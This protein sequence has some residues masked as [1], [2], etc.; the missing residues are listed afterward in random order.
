MNMCYRIANVGGRSEEWP[1]TDNI[2]L[3][4]FEIF[5][6]KQITQWTKKTYTLSPLPALL[7]EE[8]DFQL[9]NIFCRDISV[10]DSAGFKNKLMGVMVYF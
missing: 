8:K 1:P 3:L 5:L 2:S 6:L 7:D 4:L 9:Y 10:R